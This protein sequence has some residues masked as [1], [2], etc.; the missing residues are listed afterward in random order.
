MAKLEDG[1][2][3]SLKLSQDT[4]ADQVK[5]RAKLL[6][7]WPNRPLT[8]LQQARLDFCDQI[9]RDQADFAA[10]DQLRLDALIR[11]KRGVPWAE[12]GFP[13]PKG[14]PPPDGK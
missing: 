4:I 11:F 13:L 8:P 2:R 5:V 12:A 9:I 10:K 6:A 7:S 3:K 14:G 1:V